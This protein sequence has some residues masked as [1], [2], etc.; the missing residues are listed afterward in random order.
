MI[1]SASFRNFIL[2]ITGMLCE[3]YEAGEGQSGLAGK[4]GLRWRT[5]WELVFTQWKK[6]SSAVLNRS[7]TVGTR[8]VVCTVPEP[9]ATTQ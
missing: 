7:V 4:A 2:L 6:S 3:R 5:W 9:F 8:H 1:K